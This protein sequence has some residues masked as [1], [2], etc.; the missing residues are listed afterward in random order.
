MK[1][2]SFV[3]P[4]WE[5]EACCTGVRSLGSLESRPDTNAGPRASHV[6]P[7]VSLSFL[8]CQLAPALLNREVQVRSYKLCFENCKCH[9]ERAMRSGAAGATVSAPSVTRDGPT[10]YKRR[11]AVTAHLEWALGPAPAPSPQSPRQP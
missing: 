3:A 9:T 1:P 8:H 4:V 2:V 6:P 7:T 10:E 11:V 5:P